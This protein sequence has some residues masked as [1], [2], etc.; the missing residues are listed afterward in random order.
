MVSRVW[1]SGVQG[2]GTV[3]SRGS[4]AVG[5]RGKD[6]KLKQFADIAETIKIWKFRTI[7]LLIQMILDQYVLQWGL[8]DPL[9]G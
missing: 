8:S 2:S 7:C 5:S 9:G 4:G 1:G 6:A 3:G